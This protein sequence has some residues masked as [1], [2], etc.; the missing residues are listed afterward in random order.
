MVRLNV[1]TYKKLYKTKF[2]FFKNKNLFLVLCLSLSSVQ[3]YNILFLS[4]FNAKS[5]WL[6]LENFVQA[7]L[8][9]QHEVTCIT[10]NT[11]SGTHPSNYT[12]IL[13]D[14]ALD[15][16]SMSKYRVEEK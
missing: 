1:I 13:I 11:L 4:P 9:R 14:P 12:E 10:S 5:H 16:E 8:K 3:C 2:N 6:F 7:L 15:F